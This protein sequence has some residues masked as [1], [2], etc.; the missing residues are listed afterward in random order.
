MNTPVRLALLICFSLMPCA[1]SGELGR[2][3]FTPE[4]RAQLEQRSA[5]HGDD[6]NISI[7][8]NGLIQRSDGSRIA[9]INGKPTEV[10]SNGDPN[11]VEVT[12]SGKKSVAVKV[13]QRLLLDSP[14]PKP[15]ATGASKAGEQ[16]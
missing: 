7:T 6:A 2:L 8:V 12:T 10:G 5:N 13:G 16:P 9:W 14:S 3:F 11:V 1:Q 15:A 4:E